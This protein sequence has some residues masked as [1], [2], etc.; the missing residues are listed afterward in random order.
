MLRNF[1]RKLDDGT[2]IDWERL[3]DVTHLCTQFLDNVVDAGPFSA[4]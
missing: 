1:S 2:M 3:V 4:A